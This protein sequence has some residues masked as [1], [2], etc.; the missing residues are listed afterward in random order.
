MEGSKGAPHTAGMLSISHHREHMFATATWEPHTYSGACALQIV[1]IAF[2][3]ALDTT[4]SFTCMCPSMYCCMALIIPLG[5]GEAEV[6]DD[7]ECFVGQTDC[8]GL[9]LLCLSLFIQL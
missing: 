4:D 6:F 7:C 2:G 1:L 8:Q 3:M 5:V 9:D